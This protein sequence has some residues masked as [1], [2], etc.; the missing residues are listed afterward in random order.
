M[1]FHL[2]ACECVGEDLNRCFISWLLSDPRIGSHTNIQN[3]VRRMPPPTF[4]KSFCDPKASDVLRCATPNP[5]SNP[6]DANGICKTSTTRQLTDKYGD[7]SGEFKDRDTRHSS[8]RN[9]GCLIWMEFEDLTECFHLPLLR[10]E[11]GYAENTLWPLLEENIYCY[12]RGS[13]SK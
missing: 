1:F 4:L 6:G 2:N 7:G 3:Q 11:R 5:I 13:S 12:D 9:T 8:A 10:A